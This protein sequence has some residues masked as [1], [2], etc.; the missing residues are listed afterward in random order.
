M[1]VTV[2]HNENA[3][4][5]FLS[6]EELL[7][8][9]LYAGHQVTEITTLDLLC[10]PSFP[11]WC[12]VVI[13]AGGDG[14]ILSVARRLLHSE[15]PMVV[16][17]LG[18]ANNLARALGVTRQ[19]KPLI[20]SLSRPR[21]QRLDLGCA[22]GAW[23]SKYFCESAGVGWFCE[24]LSQAV[25]DGDKPTERA[26]DLLTAFLARYQPRHWDVSIDGR[27][28][29]GHYL[30]VDA[31]NAGMLGP[32]LHLG[33]TADPGD[34]LFD[35][36]LATPED[37]PKL[38]EYLEALRRNEQPPAPELHV[39]RARH[40]RFAMGD[41]K[42]RVDGKLRENSQFVD[43]HVVPAGVRV[44]LPQFADQPVAPELDSVAA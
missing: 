24:A 39:K 27:N 32:N 31:M 28:F 16:L 41:R 23:G 43:V 14:T 35:V 29:S 3:G 37:Q 44:L 30:M 22:V 34:G 10:A 9:L 1:R 40:V 13:A 2:V 11:D 5:G 7:G 6:R 15:V 17:P 19:L 4:C 20:A 12:D 36:V 26:R 18:T 38:L 21:I 33:R 42:L 8:E 25:N